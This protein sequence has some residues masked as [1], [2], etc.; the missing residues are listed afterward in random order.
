M[1]LETNFSIL[2]IIAI[3]AWALSSPRPP[4]TDQYN[5]YPQTLKDLQIERDLTFWETK[6]PW[7][8]LISS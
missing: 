7:H 3:V 5:Q 6:R 1:Q 4:A 2:S 8:S